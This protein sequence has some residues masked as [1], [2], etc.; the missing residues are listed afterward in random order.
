M[1][2]IYFFINKEVMDNVSEK[3]K[4]YIE[5]LINFLEGEIE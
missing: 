5:R 4:I 1:L 3:N 2:R